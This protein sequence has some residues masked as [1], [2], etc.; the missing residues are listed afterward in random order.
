MSE[1]AITADMITEDVLARY[2]Q[3]SKVF[4]QHRLRCIG[5]PIGHHHKIA[6]CAREN[7]LDLEALLAELNEA[8]EG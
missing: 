2:P 4:L 3:T 5:C 1:R 6:D 8:L 7:D